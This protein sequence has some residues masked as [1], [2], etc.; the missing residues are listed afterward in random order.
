M[1]RRIRDKPVTTQYAVTSIYSTTFNKSFKTKTENSP[2][3][4]SS[5]VYCVIASQTMQTM[6]QWLGIQSAFKINKLNNNN[7][8]NKNESF[9]ETGNDSSAEEGK[10]EGERKTE[11]KRHDELKGEKLQNK[12]L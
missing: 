1:V 2:A 10:S 11:K 4:L 3:S 12:Q 7:N 8:N 6:L 9:G 5:I